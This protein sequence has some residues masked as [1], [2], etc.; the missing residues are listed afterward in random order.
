MVDHRCLWPRGKVL[1][2]SSVLNSMLYVRGNK[3]DYDRWEA[4]GNPGWSYEDVLPYFKKSEDN[5]NFTYT[6]TEYHS[7]DGYLSV[8]DAPYATPFLDVF[9]E[10][11]KELGYDEVDINGERQTGFTRAQGKSI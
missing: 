1:G 6:S 7:S 2:G 8:S 11:G 9:I 3:M 4:L 5:N 10:A